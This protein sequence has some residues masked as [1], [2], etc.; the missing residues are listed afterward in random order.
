MPL[1]FL[2]PAVQKISVKSSPRGV[3]GMEARPLGEIVRTP[4]FII[5]ALNASLGYA[6]MA[7]VMTATPLAVQSCGFG[8]D[9]SSR[10]IQG[11]V[12]A[13]FLP[14]LFTGHLIGRFGIIP[15]LLTG[16]ALFAIAFVTALSGIEIWHFSVALVALGVGWNFCF[17]GG[18]TLLTQAHS[19]SEKGKAQGLNEFIVFGLSA[20]ASFAAGVILSR[21]GWGTVNQ[22]AF[23][24]LV[25]A[26]GATSLWGIIELN[27]RVAS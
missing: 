12:I 4:R 15:I 3:T 8:S 21:Y 26:A 2:R 20:T 11:H 18:S 6:M 7:F 24:M 10:V 19:D 1:S 22:A 23:V 17:V 27:R 9:I 14:S 16:H 5:A 13:M 25:V